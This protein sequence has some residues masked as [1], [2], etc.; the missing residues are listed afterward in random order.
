[1]DIVAKK[2]GNQLMEEKDGN[3]LM[4]EKNGKK[5]GKETFKILSFRRKLSET[6][7]SETKTE[8]LGLLNIFNCR[9]NTLI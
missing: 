4:D 3:P 8:V 2:D 5:G 6:Q 1:M 9:I 7:G